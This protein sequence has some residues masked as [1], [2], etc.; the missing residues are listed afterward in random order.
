MWGVQ[1][2]WRVDDDQ[3]GIRDCA[4]QCTERE[5]DLYPIYVTD[6]W[7][8]YKRREGVTLVARD[9]QPENQALL[10]L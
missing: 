10:L 8:V 4:I 5:V 7:Q 1:A 6:E 2:G 9:G 3:A